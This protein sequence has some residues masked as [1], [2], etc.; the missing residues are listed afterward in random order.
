MRVMHC[1]ILIESVM[2]LDGEEIGDVH[3]CTTGVNSHLL[4]YSIDMPPTWY[5]LCVLASSYS[6]YRNYLL[7]APLVQEFSLLAFATG[8]MGS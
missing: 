6:K 7:H 1:G 4:E 2:L 8:L 5:N 3:A